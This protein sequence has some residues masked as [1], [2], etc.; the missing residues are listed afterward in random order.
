MALYCSS[1]H[2]AN[3]AEKAAPKETTQ[4]V[5]LVLGRTAAATTYAAASAAYVTGKREKVR[6]GQHFPIVPCP[7]WYTVFSVLSVV[8]KLRS[9]ARIRQTYASSMKQKPQP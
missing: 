6:V 9:C 3:I 7:D 2:Q 4:L 1:S 8:F 5:P